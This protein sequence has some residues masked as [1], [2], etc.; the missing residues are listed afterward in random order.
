LVESCNT[1]PVCR[2]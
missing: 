2:L 1:C